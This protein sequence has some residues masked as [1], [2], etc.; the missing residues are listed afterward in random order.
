MTKITSND[1]FEHFFPLEGPGIAPS[2]PQLNAMPKPWSARELHEAGEA[3]MMRLFEIGQR[4]I[5]K[6]LVVQLDDSAWIASAL[7]RHRVDFYE[8]RNGAPLSDLQIAVMND[9]ASQA[10]K[11]LDEGARESAT[12]SSLHI[13]AFEGS[14]TMIESLASAGADVNAV[15][16]WGETPALIAASVGNAEAL[17]EL[18]RQGANARGVDKNGATPLMR[19]IGGMSSACAEMLLS[20][21]DLNAQDNEG[22]CAINYVPLFHADPDDP[23]FDDVMRFARLVQSLQDRADIAGETRP[24]AQRVTRAL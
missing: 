22:N 4:K 1:L 18:L 11:L 6:A 16:A 23:A 12:L 10:K 2:G 17:S 24:S 13:A 20:V 21:S 9:D 15:S 7:A 3:A 19:A 14:S 5:V 8:T